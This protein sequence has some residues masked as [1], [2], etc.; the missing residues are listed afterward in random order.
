MS[1]TAQRLRAAAD[2][3]Q[4]MWR[5]GREVVANQLPIHAAEPSTQ[6]A[7]QL[8]LGSFEVR[9]DEVSVESL[10]LWL[11]VGPVFN[12]ELRPAGTRGVPIDEHGFVRIPPHPV[13][14][15]VVV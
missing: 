6:R 10:A 15:Q 9:S 1:I 3:L 2:K 5:G 11:E 7:M 8:L 4:I 12:E 13:S 14:Q